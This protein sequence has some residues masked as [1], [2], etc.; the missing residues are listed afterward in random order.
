M[1]KHLKTRLIWLLIYLGF[2]FTSCEKQGI[3]DIFPLKVGNEF[4]YRY[5]KI[6]KVA[7]TRGTESWKVVTESSQGGSIKYQIERKLNAI[8]ILP[9]DTMIIKDN[10]TYLEVNENKS[11]TK[12]SLWDF[13]FKRY[14]SVSQIELKEEGSTVMPSLHVFLKQIVV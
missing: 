10:I 2:L 7:D 5:E 3:Y 9:M 12:I 11:S 8:V 1:K 6:D 14:Q 13:L 4:Y